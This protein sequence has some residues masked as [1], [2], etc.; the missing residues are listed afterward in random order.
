MGFRDCN[1]SGRR[2]T[3]FESSKTPSYSLFPMQFSAKNSSFTVLRD[4][5]Q[6][7]T[8]SRSFCFH[9]LCRHFSTLF[10][11]FQQLLQYSHHTCNESNHR[12]LLTTFDQFNCHILHHCSLYRMP[13]CR[14]FTL[15]RKE[16]PELLSF[17]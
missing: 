16:T 11:S 6:H 8:S 7:T 14:S 15:G 3:A 2:P 5:L 13:A 1:P 17:G 9:S 10:E 4:G 12:S